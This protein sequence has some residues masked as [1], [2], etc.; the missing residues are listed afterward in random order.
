MQYY[1]PVF[2]SHRI[3]RTQPAMFKLLKP[4]GYHTAPIFD[5]GHFHRGRCIMTISEIGTIRI[6]A[7]RRRAPWNCWS[8]P[9]YYATRMIV[10]R[11]GKDRRITLFN[12]NVEF[13]GMFHLIPE[14]RRSIVV[15]EKL[16]HAYRELS[17]YQKNIDNMNSCRIG[18]NALG[19]QPRD[20]QLLAS[21]EDRC[22][23]VVKQLP[24]VIGKS[25]CR[26]VYMHEY[27]LQTA[28][29]ELCT[30]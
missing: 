18:I 23:E 22:M 29:Y 2:I 25:F 1:F 17:K 3:I 13:P 9:L 26:I 30:Q 28:I 14:I 24:N 20:V 15:K 10:P 16:A 5:R 27:A 6:F 4:D 7:N 11:V 21:A 12:V 19:R 8:K